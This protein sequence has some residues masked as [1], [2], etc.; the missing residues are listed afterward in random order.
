[1]GDW[2]KETQEALDRGEKPELPTA[3]QFGRMYPE[4]RTAEVWLTVS[5][6]ED[7]GLDSIGISFFRWLRIIRGEPFE[8]RQRPTWSEDT[9][10]RPVWRFRP[11]GD[12]GIYATYGDD[13]ESWDFWEDDIEGLRI[14]GP[15]IGGTDMAWLAYRLRPKRQEASSQEE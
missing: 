8:K 11:Y 1:M 6:W 15:E 7:R 4:L 3:R 13:F 12:D 14:E 10:Y 2:I 5:W 9:Y